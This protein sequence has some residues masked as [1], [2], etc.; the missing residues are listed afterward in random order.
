[1]S[2]IPDVA[3]QIVEKRLRQRGKQ[4]KKAEEAVRRARER[5]TDT[6]A[7]AGNTGGGRG[8][9]T[10]SRVER[11]ALNVIRAEKRLEYVRRW[12]AVVRKVDEVYPPDDSSEGFVASMIYGNGMSQAD[13]ARAG[14][15]SRQTV[16]L[17]QDRYVIRAAF[18]AAQAGLIREEVSESGDP[19][20]AERGF[21]AN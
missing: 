7:P 9:N 17:R 5:A 16:K 20:Q 4:L 10:S 1:M 3:Y 2:V 8:R 21:E 6:S 18:L 11:G 13:L 19:D 15:C 12:E 14:G